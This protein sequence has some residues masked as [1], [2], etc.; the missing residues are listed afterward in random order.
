MNP[1]HL[2]G[3]LQADKSDLILEF[4]PG[5]NRPGSRGAYMDIR[6][7]PLLGAEAVRERTGDIHVTGKVLDAETSKPLNHFTVTEGRSEGMPNTFQWFTTR[8]TE[9]TN[10]SLDLFLNKGR[11]APDIM[12]EAEGYVPQS[13]GAIRFR[14]SCNSSR[15]M[16]PRMI[17][18][19]ANAKRGTCIS[20]QI[21]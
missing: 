16:W 12:V 1:F 21:M 3:L 5:E 14:Y 18:G 17:R 9:G 10:G 2:V 20:S 6:Q 15:G 7:E 8:Q 13:S 19:G 4:E 11:G